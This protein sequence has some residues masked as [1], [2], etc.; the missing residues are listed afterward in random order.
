MTQQEIDYV[1]INYFREIKVFDEEFNGEEGLRKEPGKEN[2]SCHFLCSVLWLHLWWAL[3]VE[4][5]EYVSQAHRTE[6]KEWCLMGL[7]HKY[8]KATKY[9]QDV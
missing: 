3:P 7:E 5:N 4:T 1:E 2:Y 9:S 6:A 8:T